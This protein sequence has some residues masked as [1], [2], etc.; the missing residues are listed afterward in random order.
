MSMKLMILGL[1]METDRHPYEMRQVIRQRNW[2]YAFKLRDGSL[3]YAVDQMRENGLIEAV[4]VVPVPGDNRPDKTIYRI[5]EAG[6]EHFMEL[7]YAQLELPAHPQHPMMMAMPFLRHGNQ[8]LIA[9]IAERQLEACQARI[10]KLSRALE[11]SAGGK[12]S[13]SVRMLNG[14]LRYARAEEAWLTDMVAEA[15]SGRYD[16]QR[17]PDGIWRRRADGETE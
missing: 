2:D 14:M 3:Y 7:F 9:E 5:T 16:E 1:L 13:S 10:A 6:R 8:P 11:V 4:E 17:D 12:P 15:K